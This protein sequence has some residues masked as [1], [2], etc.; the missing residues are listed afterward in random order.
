MFGTREIAQHLDRSLDNLARL[1]TAEADVP[2]HREA[3]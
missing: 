2:E 1:A 3:E